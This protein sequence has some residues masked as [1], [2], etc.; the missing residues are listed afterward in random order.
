MNLC[1]GKKF[2]NIFI[3]AVQ[4]CHLNLDKFHIN[5]ISYDFFLI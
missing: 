3:F 2:Q 1:Q 4:V 5:M